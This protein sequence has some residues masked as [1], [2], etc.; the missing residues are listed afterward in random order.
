[1][2]SPSFSLFTSIRPPANAEELSYLCECINSWRDAGFVPVAVNGP[3]E[4]ARLRSLDMPIEFAPMLVD[5]RP[6]IGAILSAIRN[7][8]E[9]FAGIL[10]A[11]CQIMG[12]PGLAS[13]IRSGLDGNCILAWRVDVGEGV[14]PA[15]TSHGFDAYFFDTRF[16]PADDLGFSIGDCWW[17]Y[18]FPLACEMRGA[19]LETLSVPLLMHRVHPINWDRRNWE[20]GASRFW[21][22]LRS[23]RPADPPRQ[24]LFSII[25]TTWWKKPHL[26][27][28]D[29]ATLSLITPEWFYRARPQRM[30]ILPPEMAK[31]EMMLAF[32]GGALLEIADVIVAMNTL[33]R[34]IPALRIVVASFRR[35]R[36]AW[37]RL[38]YRLRLRTR[39]MAIVR[40]VYPR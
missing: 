35:A 15:A 40:A 25:P 2:T 22:A 9:R 17:D 12:Y 16:L 13:A 38:R 6:R 33:K 19:K 8:G 11:D 3:K 39:A 29:Q 36:T 27:A 20:T 26:S 28:A 7:S 18:W 1:M 23:W 31:V 32:G 34:A 14:M 37:M 30:A 4:T 21:T 24:S 5:G 10:N